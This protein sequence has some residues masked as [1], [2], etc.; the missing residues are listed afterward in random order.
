MPI[1]LVIVRF[2]RPADREFVGS[3]SLRHWIAPALPFS[4]A[5]DYIRIQGIG[6][7]EDPARATQTGSV[8]A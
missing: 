3:V 8:T 2:G 7:T 6:R 1:S 4:I 5:K